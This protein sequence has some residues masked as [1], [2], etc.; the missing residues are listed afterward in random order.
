MKNLEHIISDLRRKVFLLEQGG[1][2]PTNETRKD[3]PK[4]VNHREEYSIG[5]RDHNY[6][7][8]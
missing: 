2:H 3:F 5:S 6:T 7:R 8:S 1:T 4:F